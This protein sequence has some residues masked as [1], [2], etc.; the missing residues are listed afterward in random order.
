VAQQSL[1]VQR[2]IVTIANAADA[3][4]RQRPPAAR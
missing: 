4:V 2:C 3:H 1:L